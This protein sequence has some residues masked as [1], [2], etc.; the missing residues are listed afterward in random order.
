MRHR[1]I[2]AAAGLFVAVVCLS[3]VD[4]Q[5]IEQVLVRVNGEIVSKSEFEDRQLAMLRGRPELANVTPASAELQ[6]AIAEVTPDLILEAVDELLLIQRG[7]ELNYALGETQ[8]RDILENI[9]KSNNLTDEAQFQAALKQERMTLA[10]LRRSIERNMLINQVQS[11]EVTQKISVS[12]EEAREYFDSHRAEFSTPSEVML[13]EILIEV[14]STDRGFNA[15]QDQEARAR[16]EDARQRLLKGEP[17]P[18]LAAEVSSS[19][20][21]ANG[22]L[23]GPIHMDELAPQLQELLGKLKVGDLADTIRT[24][25][26]YQILKLE[27]RTEGRSRTFE[28]ARNDIGRRVIEGKSRA[29]M[30]KYLDQLRAQADIKWRN[31]ELERAYNQALTKRRQQAGVA[32]P[33]AA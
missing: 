11:T 14:P 24:T 12:E 27:S 17:F 28:E 29:A 6:R 5:V 23:I 26:G 32:P 31:T 7:R 22:G 15:A 19:P 30:Q 33:P 25:R 10:D 2:T 18:R 16:A 1:F 3:T 20:S 13:R 8:F 4:A 9:K 21:K